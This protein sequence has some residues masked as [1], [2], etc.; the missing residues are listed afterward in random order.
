MALTPQ[1]SLVPRCCPKSRGSS[2]VGWSSLSHSAL[3]SSEARDSL[4]R[5]SSASRLGLLSM[6]GSLTEISHLQMSPTFSRQTISSLR[7]SAYPTV[8]WTPW[9]PPRVFVRTIS[10][11]FWCPFLVNL[12]DRPS[13]SHDALGVLCSSLTCLGGTSRPLV[14]QLLVMCIQQELQ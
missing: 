1:W 7:V 13:I 5:A 3:T 8:K 14:L 12:R 6:A 4:A 10:V 11:E 9:P 2:S